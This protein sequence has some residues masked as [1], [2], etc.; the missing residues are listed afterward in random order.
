[1]GYSQKREVSVRNEYSYSCN[2]LRCRP[3]FIAC[4]YDW[5]ICQI[6]RSACEVLIPHVSLYRIRSNLREEI[7]GT[8]LFAHIDW[9]NMRMA[10]ENIRIS[11][12]SQWSWNYYANASRWLVKSLFL[13]RK[14]RN[15]S[16][17]LAQTKESVFKTY[18]T[19]DMNRVIWPSPR[20]I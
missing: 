10:H 6:T 18:A 19:A 14:T 9:M 15:L 11:W 4:L 7:C 12:H 3:Q 8:W 1:M 16:A 20:D 13:D 2:F 17:G 5:S